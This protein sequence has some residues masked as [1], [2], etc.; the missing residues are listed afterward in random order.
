MN[1]KLNEAMNEISDAHIAQAAAPKKRNKRMRIFLS[2]T[3][4]VLAAAILIGIFS[5]P[6]TIHADAVA[7][8]EYPEDSS[9]VNVIEYKENLAGFFTSTL[10]QILGD[11]GSE[12]AAFSPMN[13]YFA[14]AMLAEIADG[15]TRSQL[16]SLLGA[17]QTTE[18]RTQSSAL[19]NSAY[20]TGNN[21]CTLANSL[22]L[23]TGIQYDQSVMDILSTDYYASVYQRDLSE[24]QALKDI[25][26]WI[27]NETDGLL[28]E[29][30]DN[31]NIPENA[32]LV[33]ASTV[34]LQARWREK[35]SS[36]N[37]TEGVFHAASGDVSCTFM[38]QKRME[39]DYYWGEN[40]SAVCKNLEGGYHM[41]LILPDEGV[42][43][44][45]VLES[46]AYTELFLCEE[47]DASYGSKYMYINLS[48]PKFD[49][50][51]TQDLKEDLQALGVSDVFDLGLAD[52]SAGLPDNGALAVTEIQQS[53]RICVDEDGVKA[54]TY[55]RIIGEG[56]AEP[57]SDEVDFV[58]DRPF[59]F[60]I[61]SSTDLPLFA[62]VI[63]NP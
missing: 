28:K 5:G 39:G 15:D 55:I 18:L 59:L 34:Y 3:A 7:L 13:L 14:L 51:C 63:N 60:V 45:E 38:N 8:A 1:E 46:G 41:W 16:L 47:E 6:M 17:A 40:Y 50:T 49:I 33:L 21:P 56:A 19:W 43:V 61:T 2:A 26:A 4:A 23:N 25:R 10:A 30:V 48:L 44:D 57:P 35:F 52:L 58:L 22:W 29:S 37:N 20:S 27:S 12:N 53:T 54:A 11:A 24:S 62:G 42:S 9:Y 32:E 31:M 36:A